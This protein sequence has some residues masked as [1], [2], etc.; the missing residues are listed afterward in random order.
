MRTGLRLLFLSTALSLTGCDLVLGLGDYKEGSA[1][2]GGAGGGGAAT[3][4]GM[5]TSSSDASSTGSSTSSSASGTGGS[6]GG[7]VCTPNVS[8]ACPYNGKAGTEGHGV[9]VAGRKIC[10][11]EGTAF[12]PCEGEVVDTTEVCGD[13]LDQDCDDT[14]DDGCACTPNSTA[15][16]YTGPAANQGVGLCVEGTQTCNA[17]GTSFGMCTGDVLPTAEDCATAADENC[18]GREAANG[19]VDD[20]A[21]C[22][23]VGTTSASC[24]TGPSNTENVGKCKS[25]MKACV[26]GH[27]GACTGQTLPAVESCSV[28]GDE[29]C[30]GLSCSE[31]AWTRG[32]GLGGDVAVDPSGNVYWVGSFGGTIVI[33]GTTLVAAGTQDIFVSKWTPDGS[34][35]WAKRYGGA[36]TRVALAV[37]A[38]ANF[39]YVQTDHGADFGSGT[40]KQIAKLNGANGAHVWSKG[41][42]L[43]FLELNTPPIEGGISVDPTG[44]VV[45]VGPVLGA[46]TVTCDGGPSL[47]ASATKSSGLIVKYSSTGTYAWGKTF[48][49]ASNMFF[50]GV[51]T[52]SSGS[53]WATGFTNLLANFGCAGTFVTGLGPVVVKFDSSGTCVFQKK[54]GN[55][56]GGYDI[57]IDSL[58]GP[59]VVGT[60]KG[61]INLTGVNV[62]S[63]TVDD[64]F[65]V[66]LTSSGAPKWG[67]TIPVSSFA[68]DVDLDASDNP[69]VSFAQGSNGF[70]RKLAASNGSTTWS[71]SF[72][73]STIG[74]VGAGGAQNL[75]FASGPNTLS[76]IDP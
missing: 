66:K 63:T 73:N 68:Y 26:A 9:C 20:T 3:T 16:C 23:C 65:V 12:G 15:N 50:T 25:G 1:N 42:T 27:W 35:I 52:D 60:F 2:T 75:I 22:E 41:C 5:T 54:F 14:P 33:G 62:N 46:S 21:G 13:G 32:G 40:Q 8:E 28:M 24:Y 31:V 57:A 72:T 51:A 70:V 47:S 30:N 7:M 69:V 19:G 55:S 64:L 29:D 49:D 18:N 56:G 6:G 67:I 34:L 76:R 38:D 43:D 11:P 17:Q 10:N 61:T 37:A 71:R 48:V 45:V 4:S 36:G 53:I 44:A 74:G 39:V 59:T 58:G